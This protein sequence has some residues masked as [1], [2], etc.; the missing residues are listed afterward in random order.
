MSEGFI[1][2]ETICLKFFTQVVINVSELQTL[3]FILQ[4]WLL[5]KNVHISCKKQIKSFD[6]VV[7]FSFIPVSFFHFLFFWNETLDFKKQTSH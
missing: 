3:L 2:K 7:F 6:Q 1:P 5:T 4:T